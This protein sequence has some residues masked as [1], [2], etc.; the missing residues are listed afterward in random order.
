MQQLPL[1]KTHSNVNVSLIKHKFGA[2]MICQQC[3]KFHLFHK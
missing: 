1:H 2:K 3:Q